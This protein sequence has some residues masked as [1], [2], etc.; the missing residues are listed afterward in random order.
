MKLYP[1]QPKEALQAKEIKGII[2]EIIEE[3]LPICPVNEWFV[4]SVGFA[5]MVD[6]LVEKI[7]TDSR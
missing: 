2:E 7:R 5:N 4:D 1:D 6:K 3:E